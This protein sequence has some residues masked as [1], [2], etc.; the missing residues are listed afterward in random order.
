MTDISNL[1]L[2]TDVPSPH[3]GKRTNIKHLQIIGDE[4][5]PITTNDITW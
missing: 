4:I 2:A 1:L 3:F 5:R